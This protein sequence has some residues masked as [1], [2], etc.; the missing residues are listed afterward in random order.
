MK[1]VRAKISEELYRQL[2]TLVK[3]GWFPSREEVVKLA[4]QRFL[5]SHRPELMEKA[6]LEDV[7]WGLRGGK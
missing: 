4:L 7:E 1:N 2:D 6:I 3:E 5:D